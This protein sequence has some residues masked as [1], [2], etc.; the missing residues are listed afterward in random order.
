MSR[1]FR[2]EQTF[3]LYSKL[4]KNSSI[5]RLVTILPDQPYVLVGNGTLGSTAAPA[6]LSRRMVCTIDEF[7]VND[8]SMEYKALSYSWKD[9]DPKEKIT[10]I[11]NSTAV[12]ISLHLYKALD[13]LRSD[14]GPVKVWVDGLCINQKDDAER[15]HQVKI[16]R[17]IY[18]RSTE[19]IVWL[20][21]SKAD[22]RLGPTGADSAS[23]V[24][25]DVWGALGV[26]QALASGK[27]ALDIPAFRSLDKAGPI[28]RGFEAIA[29]RSW[30]GIIPLAPGISVSL[31]LFPVGACM[32]GTGKWSLPR[33]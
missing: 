23:L 4:P 7:N 5:A 31:T 33:R 10:I 6:S 25:R 13:R 2:P 22:D 1:R 3:S 29:E 12:K 30:V 19:V 26:V 32:G 20:G 11:C 28:M 16:M 21:D 14:T 17:E 18:Q 15:T 8:V 24:E 27:L 9:A